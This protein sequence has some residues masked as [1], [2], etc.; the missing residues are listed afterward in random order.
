MR[1]YWSL[2]TAYA[3]VGRTQDAAKARAEIARIYKKTAPREEG[4]IPSE[5]QD[6]PI[7]VTDTAAQG[8]KN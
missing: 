4:A 6:A 5:Q 7:H 8:P 3:R 1:I 2:A